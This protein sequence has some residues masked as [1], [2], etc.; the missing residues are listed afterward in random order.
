[1][2]V[3][4][5]PAAASRH[6]GPLDLRLLIEWLAADGVIRARVAGAEHEPLQRDRIP[7][8]QTCA[9]ATPLDASTCSRSAVGV[10]GAIACSAPRTPSSSRR[11]REERGGR[12]VVRLAVRARTRAAATAVAI[13]AAVASP[14]VVAV[15]A[16]VVRHVHDR[17]E[18]GAARSSAADGR[19]AHAATSARPRALPRGRAGGARGRTLPA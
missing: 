2:S 3:V 1:M 13:P 11:E 17:A 9:A 8:R 6:E 7:P 4:L 14:A 10:E 16:Q 15:P 5:P 18:H 12:D 19:P